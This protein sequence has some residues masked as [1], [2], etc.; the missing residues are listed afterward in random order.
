MSDDFSLK[1]AVIEDGILSQDVK[2][3]ERSIKEGLFN[4]ISWDDLRFSLR[5]P[6]FF[7]NDLHTVLAANGLFLSDISKLDDYEI[8][9]VAVSHPDFI[10]PDVDRSTP[11]P[12]VESHGLAIMEEY[13]KQGFFLKRSLFSDESLIY[14]AAIRH[15]DAMPYLRQEL[16][17]HAGLDDIHMAVFRN[18]V[19]YILHK[20]SLVG[21]DS[22]VELRER[23]ARNNIMIDD[24]VQDPC[25]SVAT[26]ALGSSRFDIGSHPW[27]RVR[28]YPDGALGCHHGNPR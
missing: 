7:K 25:P 4:D 6:E 9:K 21:N 8:A 1:L 20:S 16:M 3:I 13:V 12:T 11:E 23:F 22:E 10:L 27:E 15:E 2:R 17:D 19:S 24:L 5:V 26:E 18:R 28:E 14:E